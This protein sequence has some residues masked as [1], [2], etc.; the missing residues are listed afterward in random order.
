MNIMYCDHIH[1]QSFPNSSQIRP[2][3][4]GG[5]CVHVGTQLMSAAFLILPLYSLRKCLSVEPR[6][7]PTVLPV[8]LASQPAPWI[9]R[10]LPRGGW[11]WRQTATLTWHVYGLCRSK[12]WFS[13]SKTSALTTEHPSAPGRLFSSHFY[14][15]MCHSLLRC[16]VHECLLSSPIRCSGKGT[17]SRNSCNHDRVILQ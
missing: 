15:A 2:F 9:H 6:T 5:S 13:C 17:L 16:L 7:H 12:L 11:N 1:P 10:Y 14:C 8:W 3:L 4:S